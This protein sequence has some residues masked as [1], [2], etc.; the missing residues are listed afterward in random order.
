MI[1]IDGR[2]EVIHRRDHPETRALL[3]IDGKAALD[4][5]LEGLGWERRGRR[6][7]LRVYW[8]ATDGD[9]RSVALAVPSDALDVADMFVDFVVANWADRVR[10]RMSEG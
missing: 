9:M 4:G 3:A 7:T 5:Q 2:D 6:A 1:A 10:E 8:V